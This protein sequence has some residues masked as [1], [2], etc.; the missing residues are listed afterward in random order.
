MQICHTVI[1]GYAMHNTN[2]KLLPINLYTAY[3][4]QQLKFTQRFRRI[5]TY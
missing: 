2:I 4:R 5:T 3:R 1:N